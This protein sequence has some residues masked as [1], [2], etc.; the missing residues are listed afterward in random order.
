M[1]TTPTITLPKIVAF[2][3]QFAEQ[4]A[5]AEAITQAVRAAVEQLRPLETEA[6]ELD[7]LHALVRDALADDVTRLLDE[8]THPFH[9]IEADDGAGAVLGAIDGFHAMFDAITDLHE[10]FSAVLYRNP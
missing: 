3:D 1:T 9:R 10:L 7:T 8:G 6:A 5:S 4:R 2:I